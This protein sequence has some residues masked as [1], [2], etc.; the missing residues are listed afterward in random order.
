MYNIHY[1]R[2][3]TNTKR[4]IQIK[5][6]HYVSSASAPAFSYIG[7]KAPDVP[8]PPT[9]GTEPVQKPISGFRWNNLASVTPVMS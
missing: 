1:G 9:I 5:A 3:S 4:R 8:C 7:P 6:F 2:L